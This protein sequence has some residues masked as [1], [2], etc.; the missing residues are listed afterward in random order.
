MK[1]S[2]VDS[3]LNNKYKK[4][5]K[6]MLGEIR[7]AWGRNI[8]VKTGWE[9]NKLAMQILEGGISRVR[10]CLIC[11]KNRPET[12]MVRAERTKRWIELSEQ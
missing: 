1:V 4:E 8:H 3:T 2:E 6:M 5:K 9:V 10:A 7:N 11:W 12:N